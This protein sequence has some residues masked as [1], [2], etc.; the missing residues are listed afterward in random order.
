MCFNDKKCACWISLH[1]LGIKSEGC[2]KDSEWLNSIQIPCSQSLFNQALFV[3]T[4]SVK[5]HHISTESHGSFGSI[6]LGLY[7]T[8]NGIKKEVYIKRPLIPGKSLLYEACVQKLVGEHLE[9]MGFPTGAPKIVAIFKLLDGSI[10]FAMEQI[11]DAVTLSELLGECSKDDISEIVVDC[12]LQ[13]CGMVWYLEIV[14][15]INHRD[16]KP[17]NFLVYTHPP[18]V[19]TIQIDTEL[20]DIH[21]KYT[22][23]FIDFGFSC[24]GSPE[25]H[26]SELTL[27][28]VYNPSD[29]CPKDGR[30]IFLFLAFLFM[31]FHTKL[32]A[33]LVKLFDKWLHLSDIHMPNYIRKH[34]IKSKNMIYFYAGLPKMKFPL[35]YPEKVMKDLLKIGLTH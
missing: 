12:L 4:G 34:G 30:D 6:D 29:P 27:S 23:C 20:I 26:I 13:V 15:G 28:S 17:S 33:D 31:E 21:S 2:I 14:L 35:T 18:E 16:L 9:I 3:N 22:I 10:C 8:T 7:E 5:L 19:K 1:S 24:V 25:T 11:E 32:P